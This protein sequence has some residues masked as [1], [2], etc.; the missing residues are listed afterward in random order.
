MRGFAMSALLAFLLAGALGTMSTAQPGASA[1]AMRGVLAG[2]DW[3]V[4]PQ[5]QGSGLPYGSYQQTCR[6]IRNN[7]YRL[8]ATC[9]KRN[10]DWRSTSLDYRYCRGAIV[11]DNGH[12]R[13]SNS[14]DNGDRWR[15]RVPPGS[16]QQTCQNIRVDGNR[17]TASCQKR[18]GGWHDSSLRNF[19]YCRGIENDNGHLRCQ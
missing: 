6:N 7:G 17:L 12:L 11:N 8:D 14:G 9:Q 3:S 10:G 4:V 5:W 16:Y 13:C 1:G 15:G 19:N 18:N 2:N